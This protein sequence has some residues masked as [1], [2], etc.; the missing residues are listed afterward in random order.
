MD[1]GTELPLDA[2]VELVE[3]PDNSETLSKVT[4]RVGRCELERL[5]LVL[6]LLLWLDAVADNDV[7]VEELELEPLPVLMRTFLGA[8]LSPGRMYSTP[9]KGQ[10]WVIRDDIA[11]GSGTNAGAVFVGFCWRILSVMVLVKF[12]SGLGIASVRGS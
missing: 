2:L 11:R 7:P 5:L 3:T 12:F 10:V 8:V 1:E 6:L 4:C 9:G